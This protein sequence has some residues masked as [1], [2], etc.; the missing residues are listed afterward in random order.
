MEKI[1]DNISKKRN[2]DDE[3]INS[4]K[5]N[6]NRELSWIKATSTR[7]SILND[8]FLDYIEYKG[9]NLNKIDKNYD[10][11]L[12]VCNKLYKNINFTS[13]II[14]QGRKFENK[15][16]NLL[17]NKFGND[18][19]INIYASSNS[20]EK[21]EQTISCIKNKIPIIISGVVRNYVNKTFGIPDIIIRGDYIKKIISYINCD[22]EDDHYYIIDI[23]L[24]TLKLTADG[25]HLLNIGS[26]PAYKAQLYIYTEAL[27]KMQNYEINKAFILGWKWKYTC[28][29][30]KY[31]GINCFDRLGVIDFLDKDSN[32]VNRTNES[33]EW[34]RQLQEEGDTWDL[35][36]TPLPHKNLYPNMCNHMDFPYHRVKEM[37]AQS[38]NDITLLWQCGN[39]EREKA[40]K[41]NIYNW[42]DPRCTINTLGFKK[43]S[44]SV[45]LEQILNINKDENTNI[46]MPKYIQNNLGNW[47]QKTDIEFYVDF[48]S[49]CCVFNN[50]ESLPK[51]S[52]ESIIYMI[53]V[54]YI[55]DNNT[56]IYKSFITK[57]LT[58]ENELKICEDFTDYILSFNKKYN[59]IHWSNAEVMMWTRMLNRNKNKIFP[60]LNWHDLLK[61]FHIEPI[62][63]KGCLSYS[64]KEVATSF[65]KNGFIKSIWKQN[66]SCVSGIDAS[67]GAFIAEKEAKLKG[68]N[69]DE[70]SN[71]KEIQDYNEIDCKVL[72]E[73]INYLRLHHLN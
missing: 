49:T 26:F 45:I 8:G 10:R 50:F 58:L 28:K 72:E 14:E 32:F 63:I 70:I 16:I 41:L 68:L 54:G 21:Y 37:F 62:T 6:K 12:M 1:K 36:L 11:S 47:K 46:I 4:N 59:L 27:S 55:D 15:I 40:H 39:K 19:L 38:I 17:S 13:C 18:E 9:Y 29:N 42:K 3:I 31:S 33:I 53:G 2:R 30:I 48:E 25:K 7:N 24:T 57:N 69:F 67:V 35:S 44:K 43:G 5:K 34:L 61:L 60:K 73:I 52:S 65:Q 23:K 71:I 56:W 64:L 51:S 22:I 20:D 66:V